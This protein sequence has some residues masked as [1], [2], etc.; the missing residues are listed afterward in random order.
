MRD[1][2]TILGV[3]KSAT[4]EDIKKAYRK[5]AKV[6]HPD[7][8]V[9]DPKAKDK[10]AEL[11]SA[12]EILGDAKKRKQFDTGE[13]DAEGKPRFQ[14]FAGAGRDMIR[15]GGMEFASPCVPSNPSDIAGT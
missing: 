12:Y 2:Y 6:L 4:E 13:I 14:G 10:F 7:R 9:T 1:P 3:Q 11:N 15:T 8:N 5:H